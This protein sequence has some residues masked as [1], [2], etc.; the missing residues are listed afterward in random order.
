MFRAL[1]PPRSLL[2]GAQTLP[3]GAR[4]IRGGGPI[5]RLPEFDW[6]KPYKGLPRPSVEILENPDE[7]D[8]VL[9]SLT[10]RRLSITAEPGVLP[11]A[12]YAMRRSASET[13]KSH[14][15]IASSREGVMTVAD[16]DGVIVLFL[17]RMKRMPTMLKEIMENEEIEKQAIGAFWIHTEFL[18]QPKFF[19]NIRARNLVCLRNMARASFPPPLADLDGPPHVEF[20]AAL[21]QELGYRLLLDDDP[22]SFKMKRLAGSRLHSIINL[23][24]LTHCAGIETRER[25][26]ERFDKRFAVD[27]DEERV[28][29]LKGFMAVRGKDKLMEAF[30]LDA[31]E[32]EE[33]FRVQNSLP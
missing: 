30:R 12:T 23:S 3:G 15:G 8:E 16:G 29:W 5:K 22:Y 27:T 17:A 10:S 1:L 24:W 4:G 28:N 13:S 9:A 26:F 31:D 32:A 25:Y 7:A 21:A 20:A 6:R 33:A 14:V 19:E 11:T 2:A 18:S